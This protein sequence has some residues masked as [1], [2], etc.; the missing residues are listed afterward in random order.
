M[1]LKILQD[2]CNLFRSICFFQTSQLC[3]KCGQSSKKQYSFDECKVEVYS[4]NKP[5]C[6]PVYRSIGSNVGVKNGKLFHT[7]GALERNL[8]SRY[9]SP[10]RA[11]RIFLTSVS[12]LHV[13][14]LC[15]EP[16]STIEKKTPRKCQFYVTLACMRIRKRGRCEI[17]KAVV[18]V[19]I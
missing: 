17:F 2:S 13:S 19:T 8:R 18:A 16:K 15:T 9:M 14:Q 11:V 10:R 5:T 12:H 3:H 7:F 1:H 4:P 6:Y